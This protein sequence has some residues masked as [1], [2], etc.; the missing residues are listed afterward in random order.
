LKI[1]LSHIM[2]TFQ[3]QPLNSTLLSLMTP[4]IVN[5][6]FYHVAS[7]NLLSFISD[8]NLS[9]ASPVLAYWILSGIFHTLD[10]T[11]PAYFEKRR[12]HQSQDVLVRNKATAVEVLRAVILQH[13]IQT[14]IGYMWMDDES[15]ALKKF[16]NQ[17]H[18]GSMSKLVPWVAKAATLVLGPRAGE[19]ILRHHGAHVVQW[20]YWWGIPIF[21]AFF[22]L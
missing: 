6:P 2:S 14:I 4:T 8:T 17:D 16:F 15:V 10:V 18:L 20:V 21:Q 7:P 1:P 5:P 22:F 9:L 19:D 12:F 13:T 11:K 3:Q